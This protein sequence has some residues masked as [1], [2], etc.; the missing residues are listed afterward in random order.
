MGIVKETVIGDG[1]EVEGTGETE[2]E[3]GSRVE[4]ETG[5]KVEEVIWTTRLRSDDLFFR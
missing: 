2:T 1:I 4:A 3:R 5:R